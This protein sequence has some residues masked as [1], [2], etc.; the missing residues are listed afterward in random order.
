[1]LE[2]PALTVKPPGSSKPVQ[3]PEPLLSFVN[4]LP[5]STSLN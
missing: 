4:G 2:T 1:M 3:A 5:D